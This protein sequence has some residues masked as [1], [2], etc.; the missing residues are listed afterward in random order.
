MTAV[1]GCSVWL[2]QSAEAHWQG[3]KSG[4]NNNMQ[5]ICVRRNSR[6]V[7]ATSGPLPLPR[8]GQPPGGLPIGPP[9]ASD[10]CRSCARR[11]RQTAAQ[12]ASER[13][14][15]VCLRVRPA[16]EEQQKKQQDNWR[17][18]GLEN[19]DFGI[20]ILQTSAKFEEKWTLGSLA[21]LGRPSAGF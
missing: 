19:L 15:L 13:P 1:C 18:S 8:E 20:R 4:R 21:I 14:M 12:L 9:V 7:R 16:Q 10:S 3:K 5:M 17:P 6:P 11:G 2:R